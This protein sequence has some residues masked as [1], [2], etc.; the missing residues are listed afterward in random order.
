[1]NQLIKVFVNMKKNLFLVALAALA[2]AACSD[3]LAEAPPV[4]T[5]TPETQ[6]TP[7]VF[8]SSSDN[9]ITRSNY[10]GEVAADML[11]H[12]F[13]VTGYKGSQTLWDAND[14]SKVFDNFLVEWRKNSANTTE[15]NTSNWEYVGIAP[16]KHATDN[17]VTRQAV[18]Y[19]DYT[20]DQYDFIAWSTGNV[21]VVYDA[22]SYVPGSNVLVSSI[23]PSAAFGA[24][25]TAFTMQGRAD[26]LSQCYIADLVTVTKASGNYG[27]PVTLSFRSLGTKV[28]LG[29]YETIPGYSVRDVEFYSAAKSDDAQAA[30]A[31][32]FTTTANDIYTEGTYTVHYNTVDNTASEDNNQAHISFT[33]TGTQETVVDWGS[34]NYSIA[35]DAEKTTGAV[36]LGRSSNTATFAGDPEKNYYEFY[37][38]NE[39]GTNLNL[40]VNYTLEAIDGTGEVIK[41]YGAT[42][43]IPSVYAQW[44]PGF[45]YTYLFKISDKTNGYTG[46]GYDP[47]NPDI[48]NPLNPVGLYPITFDAVVANSEDAEQETITTV[49]VPSIT[50]YQQGSAVVDN[51][52]Y[53]ASTGDIFIT[54]G[55]GNTLQNL[56]TKGALYIVPDGYTEADVVDAMQM[57]DDDDTYGTGAF[58]ARSGDIIYDETSYST[59]NQIEFGAD[60]NAITVGTDMAMRFSPYPGTTYAFVYTKKSASTTVAK[61]VE[62]DYWNAVGDLY[63][64]AYQ[65][66]TSGDV[67]EGVA[68]FTDENSGQVNVFLGQNVKGLKVRTG[69]GT[70]ASPYVYTEAS[71][72]AVSGTA[73]NPTVYCYG[74]TNKVA[75]NVAYGNPK[76]QGL[77]EATAAGDSF[78][79]TNDTAPVVGKAYYYKELDGSYTFCVMLPQQA[80]GLKVLDKTSYVKV[81]S[82]ESIGLTGV[83]YFDKYFQNDG[84][85][86]AKVIKVQ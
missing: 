86:Y 45:A 52:E 10:T 12:H 81:T 32:L 83:T 21:P 38:P 31:K 71:G 72:Y 51:D 16:I 15:S 50:T 69:E 8:N 36:Y 22:T 53:L 24:T 78:V 59:V 17:G 64:Y 2:F 37:L 34:M 14:N 19:W 67:Q 58:M 20:K 11:G 79:A 76:T 73:A 77:F 75:L 25:G 3:D 56:S 44:Q 65:N 42:A 54:V 63:R 82:T 85:Y 23:N 27:K 55:D 4:V 61:Y 48:V 41:V 26:D 80:D 13:V 66:A 39:L 9:T 70:T 28:R 84:E 29:V 49:T 62:C 35:E 7:I 18:K 30:R 33:G 46:S 43:Q 68:Y 5:P 40:R 57:R 6:E 47:T 74:I 60:G 1:M